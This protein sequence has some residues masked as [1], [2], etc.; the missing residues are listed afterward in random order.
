MI[1]PLSPLFQAHDEV[2]AAMMPNAAD[3][4]S[5]LAVTIIGIIIIVATGFWAIGG[6][7]AAVWVRL[8]DSRERRLH[9]RL[10]VQQRRSPR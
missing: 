1:D 4:Q 7:S 10:G 5:A 3:P 9:S 2:A 6:L 8:N